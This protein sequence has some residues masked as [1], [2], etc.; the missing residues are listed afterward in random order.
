MYYYSLSSTSVI[1]LLSIY[2]YIYL[3]NVIIIKFKTFIQRI[4]KYEYVIPEYLSHEYTFERWN[5]IKE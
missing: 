2:I 5:K 1:V 3:L 4:T